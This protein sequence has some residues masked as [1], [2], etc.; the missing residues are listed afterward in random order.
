[1]SELTTQE[2]EHRE[3]EAIE[4]D[5]DG[6]SYRFEDHTVTGLRIKETAEIPHDY[7]LYLLRESEEKPI[8]NDEEVHLHT[9]EHF[10]ARPPVHQRVR[11][12][13]DGKP[14]DFETHDTTGKKIKE[15]AGI[16]DDYS[17]YLRREG[18]NEPIRDDEEVHLHEGEH[19]FSRPP[20]NVS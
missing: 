10:V 18:G 3:H 9:G 16:A 13:I 4:V 11:V 19:F 14:Y 20:S 8:R 15:K 5:I 17:L 6:R 2:A 12:F 7:T 1:M